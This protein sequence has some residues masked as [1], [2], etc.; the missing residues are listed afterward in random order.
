MINNL[1]K[2]QI[3]SYIIQILYAQIVIIIDSLLYG[4]Y[5]RM[6]LI[7]KLLEIE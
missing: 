4:K 3:E 2:I 1:I 5:I 7:L 6:A